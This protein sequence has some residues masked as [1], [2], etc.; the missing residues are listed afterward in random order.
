[1]S[2][3]RIITDWW[4]ELLLLIFESHF[5][6]FSMTDFF[7]TDLAMLLLYNFKRKFEFLLKIWKDW[8]LKY[9]RSIGSILIKSW[10]WISV[11]SR[12]IWRMWACR[13][14]WR[15]TGYF[16][17]IWVVGL[18]AFFNLIKQSSYCRLWH[19][20]AFLKFASIKQFQ[21]IS[22][23]L[24]NFPTKFLFVKKKELETD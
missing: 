24:M 23:L 11:K 4:K 21:E 10:Q 14:W 6:L 16:N 9:F 20:N 2:L 8:A 13:W 5:D 15:L 19:S 12:A 3:G 1:M 22:L 18:F 17:L 7:M